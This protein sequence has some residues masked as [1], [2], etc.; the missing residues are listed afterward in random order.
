MTPQ[1]I[2]G[3]QD[4]R[5][6]TT[7]HLT[8]LGHGTPRVLIV[9]DEPSITRALAI[10]CTRAGLEVLSTTSA[11]EAHRLVQRQHV[12]VLLVDLRMPEMR[13]DVF[14]HLATSI[15]PHLRRQTLFIT[16]DISP[17]AQELIAACG[18]PFLRKPFELADV[19]EAVRALAPVALTA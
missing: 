1:E 8:L 13:G 11:D 14:Y 7:R 5:G 3:Q 19:L 12:D 16:G 6:A 15:Q 2:M 4:I 17:R 10:A 18:T 9:D